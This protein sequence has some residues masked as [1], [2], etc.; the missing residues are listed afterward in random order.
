ML[1]LRDLYQS[2]HCVRL[3]S[4][5]DTLRGL[6]FDECNDGSREPHN[7]SVIAT[8][9]GAPE[10]LAQLQNVTRADVGFQGAEITR[11]PVIKTKLTRL[12]ADT[13][14][15][16]SARFH[17]A[18]SLRSPAPVVTLAVDINP[19]LHRLRLSVLSI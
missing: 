11:R 15:G 4:G 2:R 7:V 18:L 14:G 12:L 17:V 5:T 19:A 13:L 16:A 3:P 10:I 1:K 9:R 8:L 6:I